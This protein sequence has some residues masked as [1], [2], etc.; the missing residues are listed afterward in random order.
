MQTTIVTT[1]SAAELAQ[2][3]AAHKPFVLLD[4]RRSQAVAASGVQIAGAQWKNPALWLD[5]KDQIATDLPVVLYCAHGHEISIGL[6]ATLL[7]MGVD[8][9]GL[10]GGMSGW[11][12]QG[13]AVQPFS[14]EQSP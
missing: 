7:A 3:Q 9:H 8:A 5:W 6:T 2:W 14:Q 4:V 13:Q 12:A 10:D 1:L 11:Q